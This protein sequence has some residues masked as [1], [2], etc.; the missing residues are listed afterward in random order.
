LLLAIVGVFYYKFSFFIKKAAIFVE[1]I[2]AKNI[3]LL[4]FKFLPKKNVML[5]ST[6]LIDVF[7]FIVFS[8]KNHLKIKA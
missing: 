1:I 6:V 2:R 5:V 7:G 8:S 4:Y 3:V